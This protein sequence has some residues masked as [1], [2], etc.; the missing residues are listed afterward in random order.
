[1]YCKKCGVQM[2]E[3][4]VLCEICGT[5]VDEPEVVDIV[6]DSS[7][8]TELTDDIFSKFESDRPVR[9]TRPV[10]RTRPVVSTRP[11]NRTRTENGTGPARTRTTRKSQKGAKKIAAVMWIIPIVVILAIVIAIS[12]S[13]RVKI[14]DFVNKEIAFYGADGY[15][16]I[17]E[18][19]INYDDMAK[20]LYGKNYDGQTYDGDNF[21]NFIAYSV[22][23]D[24]KAGLSN[25]DVVKVTIRVN[26]KGINKLERLKKR[27]VGEDE[28]V[29][30]YKVSGLNAVKKVDIFE[31][32][33]MV[34]NVGT[35][36]EPDMVV[37]VAEK[38]E[39]DTYTITTKTTNN[40]IEFSI[41]FKLDDGTTQNGSVYIYP[42]KLEYDKVTEK[43]TVKIEDDVDKYIEYGFALDAVEKDFEVV[44]IEKPEEEE[45]DSDTKKKV[46]NV[47]AVIKRIKNVGTKSDPIFEF[48]FNN[49]DSAN[50][51]DCWLYGEYKNNTVRIT[52]SFMYPDLVQFDVP[53]TLTVKKE[54][55]NPETG[56]L[57]LTINEDLSKY[58][59]E[60]SFIPMSSEITVE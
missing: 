56:K 11:T 20:T 17:Q 36:A 40:K 38:L 31:A 8:N 3:G 4:S 43:A 35:K 33:E 25:G 2:P 16:T 12:M 5:R 47:F 45:T 32:V 39:K 52:A 7:Y 46:A 27:L 15:G 6:S 24:A 18:E 34:E 42:D 22:D 44:F 60:Y 49:D 59:D 29:I 26:Y 48:E 23:K 50:T 58:E 14:D 55:Y 54:N 53:V 28:F 19:F 57:K 1:M 10:D 51:F 13:G 9:T 21:Q 30:E 41:E 37:R